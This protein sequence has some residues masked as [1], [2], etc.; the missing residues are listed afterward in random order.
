M[1]LVSIAPL[2]L[3][4]LALLAMQTGLSDVVLWDGSR[5]VQIGAIWAGWSIVVWMSSYWAHQPLRRALV[6]AIGFAWH[7]HLLAFYS[8]GLLARYGVMLGT[9]GVMQAVCFYGLQL[10]RWSPPKSAAAGGQDGGE[11]DSEEQGCVGEP[12][13]ATGRQ[14]GIADLLLITTA[15]AVALAAVRSHAAEAT[16][17]FWL[18][19]PMALVTLLVTN[20]LA[21]LAGL[22]RHPAN[23]AV[24]TFFTVAG[25]LI[26][27]VWL[28][29]VEI[30][31]WQQA[32]G[33]PSPLGFSPLAYG[34]LLLAC[35][36]CLVVFSWLSRAAGG[37]SSPV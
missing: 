23:R 7:A 16:G 29:I 36:S 4:W 30:I 9:Y 31:A 12:T 17:A 24:F 19:L 20:L 10:P 3:Y 32:L 34:P 13:A 33:K 8:G 28:A 15:A 22:S 27:S 11:R 1:N 6:L 26:G 5:R 21:Y 2:L 18:G 35:S 14:Y 37:S 25:C